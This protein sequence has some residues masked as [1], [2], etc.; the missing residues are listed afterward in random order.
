M[1]CA[2]LTSVYPA[3]SHTFIQREIAE[4]RARGLNIE[5][6]SVRRPDP[7]SLLTETDRAEHDSTWY[8]LPVSIGRLLGAHLGAL[9]RSP[10]AYLRTLGRAVSLRRLGGK[11]LLRWC[12]YFAEAVVLA[13]E[14]RR[15]G[16]D[17]L[18]NHF[19]NP[20]AN[21]AMLA[22]E[23]LGLP[24][25]FTLH[26]G[27]KFEVEDL[28]SLGPK[29]R[30]ARFVAC[31]SDFNRS[32]AMRVSEFSDW[33]KLHLARCGLHT[34]GFHTPER[35]PRN[36][37]P[38]RIL[39]V[40]RLSSEKGLP[41]LLAAFQ[42]ARQAG[43]SAELRIIGEGPE[44]KLIEEEIRRLGLV[45]DCRLL[46]ALAGED[47]KAEY[48]RADL[49]AMASL[50]EGLP[51]VLMEAMAAGLPVIA[52]AL[53][54]IPELVVHEST[55]LLYAPARWDQLGDAMVRLGTDD[56]LYR[57]LAEAGRQRS[58]EQHD[59]SRAIEPL[60]RLFGC[61]APAAEQNHTNDDMQCC[62]T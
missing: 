55:G 41:G 13:R 26:S 44:R 27:G 20:S 22:A 18:H 1:K 54:G 11:G 8:I 7:D 24:W 37:R 4:L 33:E 31:I 62:A 30:S 21:V 28:A 48:R 5:T 32:L 40:A 58:R 43:L 59:I 60:A 61:A 34:D 57:R 12:A 51:V 38:L 14:L 56:D 42:R 15:R 47:V 6:F 36:G 53:S 35:P 52:P 39:S 9:V 46:G 3:I 29:I 50:W 25:S 10:A 49:F 45:E 23:M 17:H 19:A 2:Y 16:V